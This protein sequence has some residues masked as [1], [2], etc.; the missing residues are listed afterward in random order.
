MSNE[1]THMTMTMTLFARHQSAKSHYHCR[2]YSLKSLIVLMNSFNLL[3]MPKCWVNKLATTSAMLL[4]RWFCFALLSVQ[5]EP[6]VISIVWGALNRL[7]CG[8]PGTLDAKSGYIMLSFT[9]AK[10]VRKNHQKY[11]LNRVLVSVA[12]VTSN[13]KA[14]GYVA[15]ST[16]VVPKHTCQKVS[17]R[18]DTFSCVYP[19]HVSWLFAPCPEATNAAAPNRDQLGEAATHAW[20]CCTCYASSMCSW[21]HVLKCQHVVGSIVL[22][23]NNKFKFNHFLFWHQV[24]DLTCTKCTHTHKRKKQGVIKYCN[25]TNSSS[26]PQSWSSHH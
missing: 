24:L 8:H 4:G 26:L 20:S 13:R 11:F 22:T 15:C 5:S 23:S 3:R 12:P 2:P 6:H 10:I 7:S 18:Q 1:M 19:S 25:V 14:R 21:G 9:S 17:K 16:Q